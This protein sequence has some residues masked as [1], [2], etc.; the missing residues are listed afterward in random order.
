MSSI[1][2]TI[3][4]VRFVMFSAVPVPSCCGLFGYL[5]FNE[6]SRLPP[7][8]VS[9][10]L[11]AAV[12]LPKFIRACPNALL[13]R[14]RF[15]VKPHCV[16]GRFRVASP[17]RDRPWLQRQYGI[18]ITVPLSGQTLFDLIDRADYVGPTPPIGSSAFPIKQQHAS[19]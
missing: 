15:Q 13:Q 7:V 14:K 17:S 1:S 18:L 2:L 10:A 8:F 12:L 5:E 16:D 3:L 11:E 9:A 19:S 4:N 6:L